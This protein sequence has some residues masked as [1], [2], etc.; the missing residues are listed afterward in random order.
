ME[1]RVGRQVTL[2]DT[3]CL[4]GHEHAV[5]RHLAR[6]LDSPDLPE[7]TWAN[8]MDQVSTAASN[9]KADSGWMANHLFRTAI[10]GAGHP[11]AKP[12]EP[13]EASP[14]VIAANACSQFYRS[15]WSVAGSVAVAAGS[16][17]A[18]L[19]ASLC[20]RL[21]APPSAHRL[22]V[23]I[24]PGKT[25]RRTECPHFQAAAFVL[26]GL[27]PGRTS[28]R[29]W[30]ALVA[31][32]ILHEAG[33]KGRVGRTLR[34]CGLAYLISSQFGGD[35]GSHPWAVRVR[36]D[37]RDLDS[38]ISAVRSELHTIRT[39]LPPEGDLLRAKRWLATSIAQSQS[40]PA[41]VSHWT[42]ACLAGREGFDPD[43]DLQAI[44]AVTATEVRDT[45]NHYLH[46]DQIVLAAAVPGSRNPA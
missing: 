20:E 40:L 9:R 23:A 29:Y 14:S 45:V 1:V 5:L 22:P 27:G 19:L 6:R 39:E 31:N 46:E 11:L 17:D 26:G 43:G 32:T 15:T 12:T 25:E 18:G 35:E 21:P 41:C 13:M 8:V 7:Q 16:W 42:A 28:A 2:L 30:S 37:P 44:A 33:V 3:S 36:T 4:P 24:G 10:Y 38:A 34:S